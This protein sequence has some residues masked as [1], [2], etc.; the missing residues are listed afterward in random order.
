[1]GASGV[2]GGLAGGIIERVGLQT[3]YAS[4][5]VLMSASIALLTLNYVPLPFLSATLFGIT[6]IF[7]TG[8]FIIWSTSLFPENPSF[9]ISLS[10]LLLGIG[11]AIGTS[12]AGS[13][14]A[15]FSYTTSF[16]VFSFVGLIGLLIRTNST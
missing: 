8:V 14:I 15:T 1:M 9:G 6:Y 7:L 5:L 3:A 10:F 2:L 11:Q 13:L 4:G 12:L 16:L